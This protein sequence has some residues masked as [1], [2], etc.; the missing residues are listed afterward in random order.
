MCSNICHEFR[1]RGPLRRAPAARFPVPRAPAAARALTTSSKT[2]RGV[3]TTDEF[4]NISYSET[5]RIAILE[6]RAAALERRLLEVTGSGAGRANVA[7]PGG[8]FPPPFPE[9]DAPAAEPEG[10]DG[11][12]GIAC[13]APGG[14]GPDH[15]LPDDQYQCGGYYAGG[16]LAGGSGVEAGLAPGGPDGAARNGAGFG[17]D[18]FGDGFGEPGTDAGHGAGALAAGT[19]LAADDS[20]EPGT[21]ARREK[22]INHGRPRA[23]PSRARRL[24]AHWRLA[25]VAAAAL[26]AGVVA[27]LVTSSGPG[28]GW[29]SSVAAVQAEVKQACAN[30]D[31]A[32]EPS[33]LNFACATDSQ[34]VLWVFALLTSGGNPGYIDQSTGRRGLEPI[35]PS[36]GG[37]IAWSLNLHHPYNPA[38]PVDS[39]SVAARAINNI[40]SGAT[41]TSASGAPSVQPGLESSASNCRRYT[42]SA[43]LVTRAGY[44]A[45][46]ASAVRAGAGSAALVSD[47]F[48]RWMGS[49]PAQLASDAG[50]LFDHAGSPGNPQ[51]RAILASLPSS[52]G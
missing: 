20:A 12:P 48:R 15:Y 7:T 43:A 24:L 1:S 19:G 3:I 52:G 14:A 23:R 45:R 31:V 18:G 22:L 16:Y 11:S 42:G 30:P 5:D 28:E 33:G 9:Y 35:Q 29:P 46:C 41:L 32:A 34:Q 17:D 37:D 26:L 2:R 51:V 39:L 25:A 27:A 38:S 40:V 49:A 4:E 21:E 36:Q 8:R 6:N 47:V 13:A 10:S 44:P 50:V